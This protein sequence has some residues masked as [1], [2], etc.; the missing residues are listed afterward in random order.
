MLLFK[1]QTQI[2]EFLSIKAV[3]SGITQYLVVALISPGAPNV[4]ELILLN[5]TEKWHGVAL[6]IKNSTIQLP[7]LVS[8]VLI[9]SSI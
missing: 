3:K 2:Q 6:K 5:I 1:I 7:K 8:H 4:M 9:S